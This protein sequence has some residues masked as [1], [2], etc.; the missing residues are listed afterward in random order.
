MSEPPP[1]QEP[2]GKAFER[3]VAAVQKAIGPDAQ[4]I[5][6]DRRLKAKSGVRRQI[7]VVV[8][9]GNETTSALIA[10]EAKDRATPVSIGMVGNFYTAVDG[11]G[12]TKGILVSRMGYTKDALLEAHYRNIDA[13]ELR[14]VEE[15]DW[16]GHAR[17]IRFIVQAKKLIYDQAEI[18]LANGERHPAS[19]G[20]MTILTREDGGNAFFNRVVNTWLLKNAWREDEPIEV[21]PRQHLTYYMS[22]E[23]SQVVSLRCIPTYIAGMQV[24]SILTNPADWVLCK[25]FPNGEVEPEFFFEYAELQQVADEFKRQ[26]RTSRITTEPRKRKPDSSDS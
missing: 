10:L 22:A 24:E 25:C 6:W 11:V 12:A 2:K 18:V 17:E 9:V 14:P 5:E 23:P 3:L 7:D 20:G 13:Y 16:E 1:Q 8:H 15:K 21:V 19:P 26:P 4:R